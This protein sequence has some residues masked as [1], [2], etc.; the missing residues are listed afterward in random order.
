MKAVDSRYNRCLY[1][2]S[3]ALARKI[4]KLADKAWERVKLS[5]SHAYLLMLVIDD[6]GIQPTALVDQ[7][8][9]APSTVTRLI[10]KLEEKKLVQRKTEGKITKVYPS[11]KARAMRAV[12]GECLT[13]FYEQYCSI[14]GRDESARLAQTMN[15]I[16]DKL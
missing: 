3:H 4:E 11:Q 8:L 14:I 2:A 13:A 10:E 15:K 12:L 6:P 16:S 7:L 5:P 9:L 1:F